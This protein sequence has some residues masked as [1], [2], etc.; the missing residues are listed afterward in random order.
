M[1]IDL[2]NI[3]HS[4]VVVNTYVTEENFVWYLYN[5]LEK[6]DNIGIYVDQ[7]IYNLFTKANGTTAFSEMCDHFKS[8]YGIAD[9]N[10]NDY[11]NNAAIEYFYLF[12]LGNNRFKTIV[13]TVQKNWINI[14]Y[15]D[16]CSSETLIKKLQH[17]SNFNREYFLKQHHLLLKTNQQYVRR[18]TNF[19]NKFKNKT[20]KTQ[21]DILEW[22]YIGWLLSKDSKEKLDWFNKDVRLN[23]INELDENLCLKSNT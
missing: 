11:C 20:N 5:F 3:S 21:F 14:E 22:A 2:T 23:K 6:T 1:E 19:Y 18:K 16:F 7:L 4:A 10:D 15:E 8:A 9:I 13:S 12:L 17:L